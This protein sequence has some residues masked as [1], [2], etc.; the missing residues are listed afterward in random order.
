MTIINPSNMAKRTYKKKLPAKV[1][2]QEPEKS[3]NGYFPVQA[4]LQ[5]FTKGMDHGE[6]QIFNDAYNSMMIANHHNLQFMPALKAYAYN[7]AQYFKV[8]DQIGEQY[9]VVGMKGDE[10]I[11]PLINVADKFLNNAF[12]YS[13]QLG[14]DPKSRTQLEPAPAPEKP[15]NDGS[16]E[17]LKNG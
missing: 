13:K 11:N 10:Q 15:T 17:F 2:T 7:M 9:T 12:K 3:I 14:L 1:E 16:D 5:R 8:T 6:I 4:D